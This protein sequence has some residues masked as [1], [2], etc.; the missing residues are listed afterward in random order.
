MNEDQ[1]QM[2]A[3]DTH[4]SKTSPHNPQ[5]TQFPSTQRKMSSLL[6]KQLS[7]SIFLDHFLKG[8]IRV[9]PR[10]QVIYCGT[11]CMRG[12]VRKRGMFFVG[13]VVEDDGCDKTH[14][15]IDRS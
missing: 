4:T 10:T 3:F 1:S 7:P 12:K 6:I 8:G 13:G 14:S 2:Q 15:Y 11:A 9:L 5:K